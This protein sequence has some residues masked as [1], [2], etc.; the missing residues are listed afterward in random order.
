VT[1]SGLDVGAAVAELLDGSTFGWLCEQPAS[2]RVA[3]RVAT[4][5][6]TDRCRGIG[7]GGRAIRPRLILGGGRKLRWGQLV[8]WK[9]Q[10]E[11]LR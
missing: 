11:T 2:P 1:I 4:L 3:A 6:A 10:S 7:S 5:R 9:S 8:Q